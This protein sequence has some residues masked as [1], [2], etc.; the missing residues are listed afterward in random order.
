MRRK[1]VTSFGSFR[2]LVDALY[3]VAR[4]TCPY[5]GAGGPGGRK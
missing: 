3:N 1:Y 5:C 4:I 2:Q